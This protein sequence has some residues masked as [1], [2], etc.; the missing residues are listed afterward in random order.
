MSMTPAMVTNN[1]NGQL[2]NVAGI[3]EQKEGRVVRAEKMDFTYTMCYHW[4]INSNTC[5]HPNVTC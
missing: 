2:S 4:L 5:K 1:K 3:L